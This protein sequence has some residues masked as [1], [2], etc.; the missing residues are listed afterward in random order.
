MGRASKITPD[1]LE[2]NAIGLKFPPSLCVSISVEIC[3]EPI[4]G[5]R[6]GAPV[7]KGS[8]GLLILSLLE[9]QSRHGYEIGWLVKLRSGVALHFHVASLYP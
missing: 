4:Y 9:H 3:G 1:S 5:S 8:T 6:Y 2:K 7:E